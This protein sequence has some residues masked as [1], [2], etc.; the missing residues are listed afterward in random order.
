VLIQFLVVYVKKDEFVVLARN[1]FATRASV[2]LV[3][4]ASAQCFKVP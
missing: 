1:A 3:S 2:G 4:S